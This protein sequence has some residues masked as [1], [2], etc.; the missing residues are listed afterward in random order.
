MKLIEKKCP[1]CGASLEFNDTDKSCKCEYCKRTFEIER[2]L[3][4]VESKDYTQQFILSEIP[5]TLTI[6]PFFLGIAIFIVAFLLI[7]TIIFLGFK[8]MHNNSE[9]FNSN[10]FKDFDEEIEEQTEI[11]YFKDISELNND[12]YSKI[13]FAAKMKISRTGNGVNDTNHSYKMDGDPKRIKSYVLY[14]DESNYVIVVYQAIYYDFF[15]PDN[16]YTVYVP[17]LYENATMNSY[18][19]FQNPQIDTP[20]YYFNDEKTSYTYGY[21]NIDDIYNN[22]V[23]THVDQ[24]F[25]LSEE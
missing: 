14:K 11:K 5:A 20:E 21:T 1:N 24:G 7:F 15:N 6:I 25:K 16:R 8:T 2:D 17:L 9:S 22:V 19:V 13:D 18:N 3:D 10:F 4:K 23:K 12:Y